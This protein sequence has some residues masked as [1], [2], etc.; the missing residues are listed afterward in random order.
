MNKKQSRMQIQERNNKGKHNIN[1]INENIPKM[2]PIIA[3]GPMLL[4]PYFKIA[5]FP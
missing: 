5:I 3:I 4:V 1:T 2:N